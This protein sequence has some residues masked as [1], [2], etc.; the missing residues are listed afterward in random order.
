MYLITKLLE[1]SRFALKRMQELPCVGWG[2][3]QTLFLQIFSDIK[4]AISQKSG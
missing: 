4:Q 2:G 3:D 1:T